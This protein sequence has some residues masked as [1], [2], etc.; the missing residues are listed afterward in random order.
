M[1]PPSG[2]GPAR[3]HLLPHSVLAKRLRIS[4]E[5][6]RY[7]EKARTKQRR[8]EE[9]SHK[10][11][12][13]AGFSFN[14]P[15]KNMQMFE[16]NYRAGKKKTPVCLIA[17]LSLLRGKLGCCTWALKLPIVVL[18]PL[19]LKIVM[20]ENERP[21]FQLTW[22]KPELSKHLQIFLFFPSV[23]RER[24]KSNF[25]TQRL[26]EKLPN[27]GKN[28]NRKKGALRSLLYRNAFYCWG[29]VKLL[30]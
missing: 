15:Y 19:E 5:A 14:D 20:K 21:S 23:Q 4:L 18:L 24:E 28:Q 9:R 22:A 30:K 1:S 17:R 12:Y 13:L 16:G 2:D 11:A 10:I 27:W 26:K 7:L 6:E 29:N 8:R 25:P 3:I